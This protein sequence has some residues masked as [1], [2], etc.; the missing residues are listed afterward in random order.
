M[1]F[2]SNTNTYRFV[3]CL[4]SLS[5]SATAETVR[6]VHRE[7]VEET[8][9]HR[10]LV[11]TAVDLRTAAN[12]AILT[13]TGISTVP[14]SAIT[15]DIAVYPIAAV[16]MTGFGLLAG[17]GET[18]S[19]STQVTGKAYAAN[20][21]GD[22][23]ALL[24]AAVSDMMTAYNDAESRVDPDVVNLAEGHI[25]AL[26]TLTA[27]LY[28]FNTTVSIAANVVLSGSS[29]DIFIIQIENNLL[30][31]ADTKV[32]LAGGALPQNVFWQVAGYVNVGVGAHMVGILLVKTG[33]SF[34]T[35]SSLN[36]RVLAQTAC[37][38][39]S[40]TIVEPAE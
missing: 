36:G 13:L 6:G 4:L 27:G 30:L 22:T 1:M 14:M 35:R 20:Y 9:V 33:V 24:S 11:E 39:D 37:T 38:L 3:I 7:L 15:G 40:A 18:F 34:A 32:T 16:G 19:T 25:V 12:Y 2:S 8:A 5:L 23:P 31:S 29:T 21:L 10:E 26:T 17:E 28:N